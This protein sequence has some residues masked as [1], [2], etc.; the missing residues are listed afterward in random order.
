MDGG[1][2]GSRALQQGAAGPANSA[3][4]I[5][6]KLGH[7]QGNSNSS[8]GTQGDQSPQP[9]ARNATNALLSN[10]FL[11]P[12]DDDSTVEAVRPAAAGATAVG[13]QGA[14]GHTT[15]QIGGR[16]MM[17]G[18][19]G[20]QGAAYHALPSHWRDQEPM[21]SSTASPVTPEGAAK[22]A[23]ATSPRVQQIGLQREAFG[24]A[25]SLEWVAGDRPDSSYSMLSATEAQAE[26]PL[27]TAPSGSSAGRF[28]PALSAMA[29]RTTMRNK[30][31][32]H[33][34]SGKHR[35]TG[36][37]SS[38][39]STGRQS[40]VVRVG[41]ASSAA[42]DAPPQSEDI[43]RKYLGLQRRAP[44][45]S[46]TPPPLPAVASSY[47][48]S[49]A[50]AAAVASGASGEPSAKSVPQ[51]H[52]Q[53][54]LPQQEQPAGQDAEGVVYR[55]AVSSG[56][57]PTM[58]GAKSSV[59]HFASGDDGQEFLTPDLVESPLEALVRHLTIELFQLYVNEDQKKKRT[60]AAAG[61]QR[62]PV[63]SKGEDD[64]G[65][66]N[67]GTSIQSAL[68]GGGPEYVQQFRL[69]PSQRSGTAT[70]AVTM[71]G[72]FVPQEPEA[73]AAE[74][75]A[76]AQP[77]PRPRHRLVQRTWM[78]EALI[79]ARRVSTIDENVEE[80]I[81]Q[82]LD[83]QLADGELAAT[84][85]TSA[86]STL[87]AANDLS[88]PFAPTDISQFQLPSAATML[89]RTSQKDQLS[90]MCAG[91]S[92]THVTS[93]RGY[94]RARDPAAP[95][96][97]NAGE[98][99]GSGATGS[100]GSGA[101][102]NK[103]AVAGMS[104]ARASLMRAVG[105][106][107][108]VRLQPGKG[109]IVVAETQMS[110]AT[111]SGSVGAAAPTMA[112]TEPDAMA[113]AKRAHSLPGLM[114]VPE[115]R[116]IS[117]KDTQRRAA[118]RVVL[119][120][121]SRSR[122]RVVRRAERVVLGG[123]QQPLSSSSGNHHHGGGRKRHGHRRA[124]SRADMDQQLLKIEL[125]PPV[126]LRVRR[127][128]IRF[129]PETLIVVR[130]PS[131]RPAPRSSTDA[132]SEQKMV[133]VHN[134]LLGAQAMLS[135]HNSIMRQAAAAAAASA[136]SASGGSGLRTVTQ[137]AKSTVRSEALDGMLLDNALD[138]QLED[139]ELRNNSRRPR[140]VAEARSG[141]G[142]SSG[143]GADDGTQSKPWR[144]ARR[145][146]T[147]RRKE[148]NGRAPQNPD[149]PR[150]QDRPRNP[151]HHSQSHRRRLL[152][153]GPAYRIYSGLR[154][155][156]DTYLFLLSDVLV[157]TTQVAG[158]QSVTKAPSADA[159][160]VA[161]GSRF[162]VHIVVPLAR[163]VTA[164][165]TMR[166][167]A[168]KR[169]GEDDDAEEQRL[170]RQ[171]ERVR[172]ACLSFEKNASEAVVYLIN[173]NI[174]E[175]APDSVAAFLYRCTAL[176]R[177]Q[178]GA[179]LGAGIL[180][181]NLHEN[182]TADEIE[183]ER[184]FHRQ[185]WVA[186]LDRCNIVGVAIDVALRSVLFNVRLPNSQA[187]I[188]VLLEAAA[189]QWFA[190]NAEHGASAGVY[191]PDSQDT[192]VKLAFAIMTLNTELHN[193][194]LRADAQPDAAFRELVL[195]FRASV[196]DDPAMSARRKGNV[197]RKRDQPRV[198][199]VMEVPTVF[200]KEIYQRVRANRLVTCSDARPSAPEIDVDWVRADAD[201]GSADPLPGDQL[202][203]AL[204]DIYC[205]PGFRDG[206]LFNASSDRI[207][208][209]LNIDAPALLRV[210]VRIPA[211]EEG[212]AFRIRV[213]NADPAG[214]GPGSGPGLGASAGP[215]V[216]IV[217]ADRLTFVTSNVASFVIRPLRVGHFALHFVSEGTNARYY[218]P[219]PSRS[220][221]VE[222][223]F[224]RHTLQLSWTR[225]AAGAGAGAGAATGSGAT[226]AD[227]P[228]PA[229]RA[230]YMF[231]M[232]SYVTKAQWAHYLEAAL[233]DSDADAV[234]TA[235]ETASQAL[236]AAAS[237]NTP[238]PA[239]DRSITASQLLSALGCES[240]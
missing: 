119:K 159:G 144:N 198:M 100:S 96:R 28:L 14:A 105:R 172:R 235:A 179:F 61:Q 177:R 226:P 60:A 140:Q 139:D 15:G 181:E 56:D 37:V 204:D 2:P 165:K 12:Y 34:S 188:G 185:I 79:K 57:L 4:R 127:E 126:P 206:V 102:R 174:V 76:D 215:A 109:Q 84:N 171:E 133:R 167:G 146:S 118:R 103:A 9:Q 44:S 211:V 47:S 52:Q 220:M 66:A 151:D 147:L 155:R 202:E 81:L 86:S 82:S 136:T 166:D 67:L 33:N 148:H 93:P 212:V 53:Q 209:K 200:L 36:S 231:G 5:F 182:P 217:P 55:R 58:D 145:R 153:H 128:Q 223:A 216:A 234:P 46:S 192:A 25:S 162:R 78:E 232:D 149:K 97:K 8:R 222:G 40:P 48:S 120:R 65:L 39:Y 111:R 194:L 214:A 195:K 213:V 186:F 75:A 134:Q 68:G 113:R 17:Q 94:Y 240:T 38:Q 80:A 11:Q 108:S 18:M 129:A 123:T 173:R 138:E 183:Q 101:L 196:V 169:A 229:R 50:A 208:A 219:I 161:G 197:L 92:Q 26:S 190:R 77:K 72:Y 22:H 143:A 116:E 74:S 41:S 158:T 54:P 3:L 137:P 141:P 189:L 178:L 228:A 19:G 42:A 218:H 107:Q 160:A 238:D 121:S 224:M 201:A 73:G 10:A 99:G 62:Q 125:P 150:K 83:Q 110:G 88:P 59:R 184:L 71:D 27:E 237:R 85:D 13:R 152:L 16:Q 89:P 51:Q 175:P 170:A 115:T 114:Q 221:V 131:K 164:L 163:G 199:Q 230:R 106:R 32:V 70:P 205:D 176:S 227:A 117:Y 43:V 135:R 191:V 225:P 203:R 87:P 7:A 210:T 156:P 157:V 91:G 154:A 180:G 30:L 98:R 45:A 187:A 142:V 130:R 1:S 29:A 132:T 20:R 193:P 95:H 64:A 49:A 112:T 168:A 90:D 6:T 122:A 104:P 63:E 31:G 239:A 207:P 35:Q 24:S 69:G 236:A 233:T 23:A 21:S 124:P